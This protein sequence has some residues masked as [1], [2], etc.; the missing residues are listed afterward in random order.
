MT[1]DGN[2]TEAAT[3]RSAPEV[4]APTNRVNVALP[5]SKITVQE[6]STELAELA[7]I[8]AE[9]T[10]VMESVAPGPAVKDLRKRAHAVAARSR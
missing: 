10:E 2:V 7:A 4:V 6:P 9:L 5:F 1:H 3:P 8:V